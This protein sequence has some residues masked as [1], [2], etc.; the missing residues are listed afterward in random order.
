LY[1]AVFKYNYSCLGGK[2][3]GHWSKHRNAFYFFVVP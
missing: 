1:E 3:F 2:H